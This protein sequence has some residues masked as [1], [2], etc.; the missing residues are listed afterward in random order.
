MDKKQQIKQYCQQFKITGIS[1]QVEELIATAE[2]KSTGFLDFTVTMLKAE[3]DHRHDNDLQ[4]RI[5]TATLPV[6]SDL[7]AYDH[8][9]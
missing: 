7:N 5:K 3:A 1:K 6:G 8:T 2:K 4:R 9:V